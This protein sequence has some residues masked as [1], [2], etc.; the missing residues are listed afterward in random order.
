MAL[1]CAAFLTGPGHRVDRVSTSDAL[2][3]I[4]RRSCSLRFGPVGGLAM[5]PRQS[6]TS[7]DDVL[8][9][10]RADNRGVGDC[11]RTWWG[12]KGLGFDAET[13]WDSM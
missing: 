11:Q 8:S 10:A 6:M 1:S 2:R 12:P 9:E 3:Q 5:C 4:P 7:S 13:Y